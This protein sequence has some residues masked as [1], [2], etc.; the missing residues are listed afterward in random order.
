MSTQTRNLDGDWVT[1]I[2]LPFH[3]LRKRC[4]CGRRFWTVAGYRGHYA[5]AHVLRLED[6]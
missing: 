6:S 5:L 1:A 3:G 2:P 4:T